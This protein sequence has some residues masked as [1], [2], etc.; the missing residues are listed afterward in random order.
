MNYITILLDKL[1]AGESLSLDDQR[2]LAQRLIR[3]TEALRASC[4]YTLGDSTAYQQ[5]EEFIS[6]LEN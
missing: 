2:L 1:A 3:A 6:S 5:A 4:A